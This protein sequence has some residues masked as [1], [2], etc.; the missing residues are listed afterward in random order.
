MHYRYR[1]YPYYRRY[2]NLNPYYYGRYYNPYYNYQRNIVDSQVSDIDQSIYNYG[3]MTDV[4][5]DADVYQS[6][7]PVP[8]N[9][10][11]STEP[12]KNSPSK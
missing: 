9:I 1:N 10:G 8:K 3:G 2:Y 11:I 6:M 4:I 12:P 5:Q 7:T